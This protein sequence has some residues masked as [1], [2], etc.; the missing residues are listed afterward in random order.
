MKLCYHEALA[1]LYVLLIT[2]YLHMY[3]LMAF[4]ILKYVALFIIVK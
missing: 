1:K 4:D 3:I 2:I